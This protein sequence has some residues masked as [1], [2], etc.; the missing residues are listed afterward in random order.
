MLVAALLFGHDALA[1]DRAVPPA[2]NP[3]WQAECGSCHVAYPPRLLPAASWR[4][5]MDDLAR[6]FGT[7]ASVDP[8]TATTIRAFLEGNAGRVR[9]PGDEATLRITQTRWFVREHREVAPRTWHSAS[10]RSAAN[11]AACH[12]A[13]EAGRFSEHDVRIPR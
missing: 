2:S 9:S 8:A 13:A 5:L 11:C 7:D 3:A 12:A 10:V 4:A 6:H 1:S